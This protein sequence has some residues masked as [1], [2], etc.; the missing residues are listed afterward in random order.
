MAKFNPR[1]SAPS[2]NDKNWIHYTASGYNYCIKVNGNSCMPNCV[3]YAWGRWRELLGA[4]HRLSRNNAEVW[5]KNTSDGYSRGQEPKVGAIACWE[6]VGSLAGH[7]AVV[8]QVNSDGSIVTSNSGYKSTYF[9]TQKIKKPY[10]IGSSYKFQG[11]IYI[12]MTFDEDKPTEPTKPQT[13]KYNVGDKVIFSGVLYVNAKGDGAGQSRTNLVCTI[14]KRANGSKPY[15][16]ENGL[17][18]VAEEDLQ[19]Y[20]EIATELKVGDKVKITG[21]GNGASDGSSNTAY[22]IGWKREILKIYE[23][24]EYPYQVGNSAGTTGFYKASSLE[25]L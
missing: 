24:R 13:F 8:E 16:I 9:W 14:T 21:P 1:M 19:P 5:Y 20:I 23:G 4:Y 15:N 10:S 17:G 12:P 22:G 2:S 7:V 11:F 6:G 18:W 25:K 3:G